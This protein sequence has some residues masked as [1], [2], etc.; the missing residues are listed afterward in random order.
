MTDV[1]I[2]VTSEPGANSG[3]VANGGLVTWW[4]GGQGQHQTESGSLW[5]PV[6]WYNL[7]APERE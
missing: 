7:P 6:R 5:R 3:L 4:P 2:T 1:R